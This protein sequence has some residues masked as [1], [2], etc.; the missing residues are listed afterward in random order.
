MV[1]WEPER[2]GR[3]EEAALALFGEL[4][5]DETTVAAIAERAG[6][7]RAHVLS[8][9][10]DKR[11]VLFGGGTALQDAILAGVRGADPERSPLAAV[12]AGF[13]AAGELLEGATSVRARA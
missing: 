10:S 1:R 13:D 2:R 6:V 11:E 8:H 3:L 12:V 9:F 5:F 4:G 7:D